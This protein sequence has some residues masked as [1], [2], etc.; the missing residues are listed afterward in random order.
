MA[1]SQFEQAKAKGIVVVPI[2]GYDCN[3]AY[4]GKSN[5]HLFTGYTNYGPAANKNL[6]AFA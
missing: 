5:E 6:A 3:D 2:Y 1:R 4:S